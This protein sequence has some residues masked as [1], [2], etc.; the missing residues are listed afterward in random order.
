M[1]QLTVVVIHYNTN[2]ISAGNLCL[3]LML[4]CVETLFSDYCVEDVLAFASHCV[5]DKSDNNRPVAGFIN[6]CPL[7]R[8][9]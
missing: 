3:L 1:K 8:E 5:M 7:V 6:I 2:M 9:Q 4:L